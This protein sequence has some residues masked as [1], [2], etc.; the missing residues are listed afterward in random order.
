MFPKKA[1][2]EPRG[3]FFLVLFLLRVSLETEGPGPQ[4]GPAPGLGLW[5]HGPMSLWSLGPGALYMAH[6]P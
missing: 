1:F 4:G 6:G 2:P 3:T 5:A